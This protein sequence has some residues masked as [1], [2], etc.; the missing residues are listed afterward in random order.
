MVSKDEA[1][2]KNPP[3]DNNSKSARSSADAA[4]EEFSGTTAE[5]S[6]PPPITALESMET[7]TAE[8][9]NNAPPPIDEVEFEEESDDVSKR[10]RLY[11]AKRYFFYALA[12]WLI[13]IFLVIGLKQVGLVEKEF[14]LDNVVTQTVLPRI[15]ESIAIGHLTQEKKR[16]GFLL[17]EQGAQA[18]YP[19]IMVP[20]FVTSGL[21]IW[22]AKD[23]AKR[24]FRQRFWAALTGA[25][26]FLIERDCWREHMMLDP[27]TGLDPEGIMV[28]GSQGFE[29]AD[30]FLGNY[31]VWGKLI[32]NLADVGY[33]P[34][35]MHMAPYDWRLSFPML[36]KRDGYLTKLKYD[37]EAMHKTSGKK[38]V[39]T[40]H[41]MGALLVHY[42]F[43]WVTTSEKKGGGG[44]GKAWVED[45]IHAYVNIAGSHLGVPKA[46]TALL[47]G[48][49]SDTVFTGMMG[50]MAE[51][52]F[53]R[54]KRR[55]LWSSWG[56]LWS[57]LPKGGSRIWGIG[58]DMGCSD[59]SN[60][61]P[62]CPKDGLSPLFKMQVNND[63]NGE[64]IDNKL[65][66]QN[67]LVKDF[68]SKDLMSVEHVIDFLKEHG[69]GLGSN[70]A[71]ARDLSL[72]GEEPSSSRVWHDPT[73]TPLPHAPSLSIYCLYGVGVK[74]ERAY[75]YKHREINPEKKE[76][77]DEYD[78][79][80]VLDSDV[81]V[82]D[83][84]TEFGVRYADGDGSVPLV[85]LG[86]VCADVWKRNRH[87]L[88][89]S[90]SKIITREYADKSEFCVEDPM[91]GGPGS[92]DHVDILGNLEMTE[93][94]LRVVTGFGLEEKTA[95][96]RIVSD[97]DQIAKKINSRP[98]GGVGRKKRK[99][100]DW[101]RR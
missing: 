81:Q 24:F 9:T 23:C 41:S 40:S 48:E 77:I 32:E 89:P 83:Q 72:Y 97:I 75:Y 78:P 11:G 8:E 7:V 57:M 73:R 15:N 18:N 86:Y 3:P 88:N 49:M 39:L 6:S 99:W 43:A 85:S 14:R 56:S 65:I 55:D 13:E 59:E 66:A 70:T 58:A 98:D 61:D 30:Y 5:A 17:A 64:S 52:F 87:G 101:M 2:Q 69:A 20:G 80:V 67:K 31:W 63:D 25:R 16:P 47:S 42:F 36:E 44:G 10:Q 27:M 68:T 35:T 71:A 26:S 76:N 34:S 96:D 90:R 29:A 28:R 62:F 46:A 74:T 38:V 51:Q 84:S 100:I 1:N 4:L 45:H 19:V 54:R 33:T 21:E 79:P 12:L 92:A 82:L 60:D 50:N 37:I 93:D 94:F 53:G 22:G 95:K 91:R